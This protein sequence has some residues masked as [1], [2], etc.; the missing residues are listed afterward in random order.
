M[1]P[2]RIHTDAAGTLD[3][4]RDLKSQGL[5]LGKDF[6]YSYHRVWYDDDGIIEPGARPYAVFNFYTEAYAS[7]FVLKYVQ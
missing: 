4:V 2:I 7:F 5:V 6:D 1:T 3:L